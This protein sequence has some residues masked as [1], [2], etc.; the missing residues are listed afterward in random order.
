MKTWNSIWAPCG[1]YEKIDLDTFR[2]TI[3]LPAG[4]KT[5]FTYELT[6]RYGRRAE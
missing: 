2:Y 3:E 6:T 1:K 4:G 5:E